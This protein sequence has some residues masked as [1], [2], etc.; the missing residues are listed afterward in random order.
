MSSTS[1]TGRS[2]S[3]TAKADK[4]KKKEKIVTLKLSPKILHRF[5][6]PSAKSEEQSTASAASSPPAAVEETSTL[7]VP[8]VNDNASEAT[9]TPAPTPADA[10]DTSNGDGSKK[11]KGGPLAGTKRNLGQ[12]SEVNGLPRPRGKPGPKKK[13]RLDDGT[14]DHGGM[15]GSTPVGIN[16][17]HKLGP[18]ANQGAINAGLRA[19]D[20][21]GAP[22]RKWSKKP[23]TLKSFTGVVWEL[24]SWRGQERPQAP[25]GEESSDNNQVSQQGSSDVKP[26]ESDVAMDS[27]AGDQADTMLMSTPAASSPAPMPPPSAAIAAQ[28]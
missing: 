25:N 4:N 11:R 15:K 22:C 10:A 13:P 5:E 3:A 18:K 12:M 20:R 9:S 14:I 7:K 16:A 23:F 28:G 17:G 24:A 26:N 6:E 21:S 27:N 19:L 8:E 1:T 2:P